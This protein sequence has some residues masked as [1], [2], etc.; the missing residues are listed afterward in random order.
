MAAAAAVTKLWN[1]GLIS[2]DWPKLC[3]TSKGTKTLATTNVQDE[4]QV[5]DANNLCAHNL[6]ANNQSAYSIPIS[7]PTTSAPSTSVPTALSTLK[8]LV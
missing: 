4:S 5:P 6:S 8:T 7:L 1:A 3:K 2:K